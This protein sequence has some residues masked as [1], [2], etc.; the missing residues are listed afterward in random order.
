VA[1]V[2]NTIGVIGTAPLSNVIAYRVCDSALNDCPTGA[3]VA[4]LEE[5]VEDGADVISMSYGGIGFAQAEKHAIKAAADAGVVLVASAGNTPSPVAG[6]RHYPSGYPEVISVG[7]TDEEDALADFSTFG[8]KVDVV[9]PGVETPTTTLLGLGRE[10]LVRQNTPA[11]RL[12]DANPM[13]FSGVTPAAGI[14]A[15]LVFANLGQPADFAGI[16]C[17]GRIA[18]ISRGA[19][20]FQAKVEN[21]TADGCLGA[22]IYNNAPGNFAGTLGV[23]QTLPA[24]SLS[25]ED[26]V[27]L[28]ASLDAG[29]A[30]NVTM[31]VLASDYDTFSGTSASAPYVSGVAALVLS[32]SP[33]LT[34][35][36]VARIIERTAENLGN[37]AHDNQF[38]WGIVD[39][40]DAVACARTR[41]CL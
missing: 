9:A 22:L 10:V 32:A 27:A 35:S 18:L 31:V 33:S 3:V 28:K 11:S 12:V 36:E 39:A 37:P 30:V 2:D 16:D 15:N 19:I 29:Q 5:A 40:A 26:G 24:A 7:A 25:Q 14:T 13:E 4:G 1:A 34:N 17:T 23:P 41:S 20:S 38:G 21:A 6:A 8:G